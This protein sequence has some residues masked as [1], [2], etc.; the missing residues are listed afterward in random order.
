MHKA[1]EGSGNLVIFRASSGVS[2]LYQSNG[3]LSKDF[4]LGRGISRL[5]FREALSGGMEDAVE[6]GEVSSQWAVAVI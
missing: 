5:V 3:N 2:I 1:G 6:E 4:R